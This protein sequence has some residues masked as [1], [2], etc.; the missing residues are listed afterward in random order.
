MPL[1]SKR[2]SRGL[3]SSTQPGGS[4]N[5]VK[6]FSSR[7][8]KLLAA[9]LSYV[10]KR[11]KSPVWL[12]NVSYIWNPEVTVHPGHDFKRWLWQ[13]Q[14]YSNHINCKKYFSVA[15]QVLLWL[16]KDAFDQTDQEIPSKGFNN[17]PLWSGGHLSGH[18]DGIVFV[19]VTFNM[20]N[21]IL[22]S[23]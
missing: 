23:I 16:K 11:K 1:Q 10:I 6:C 19:C 15:V 9:G 2:V 4:K 17:Q 12:L 14:E 21:Q 18:P 22:K 8:M 7:L 3:L 5:S 13:G 20:R